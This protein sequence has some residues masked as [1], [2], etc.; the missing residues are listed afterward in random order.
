MLERW[1]RADPS[2][3]SKVRALGAI[4]QSDVVHDLR[5]SVFYSGRYLPASVRIVSE[6]SLAVSFPRRHLLLHIKRP[7][8]YSSHDGRRLSPKD[9][10]RL[11]V[12]YSCCLSIGLEKDAEIAMRRKGVAET[13]SGNGSS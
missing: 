11:A 6:E 1:S 12:H 2:L 9:G 10:S 13:Q 4:S 5:V 8:S 3:L 7:S